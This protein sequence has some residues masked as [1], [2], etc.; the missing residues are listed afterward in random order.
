MT[1]TETRAKIPPIKAG[2]RDLGAGDAATLPAS[3]GGAAGAG[4]AGGG[5]GGGAEASA[6]GGGAAPATFGAQLGALPVSVCS[7]R[8]SRASAASR[9]GPKALVQWRILRKKARPGAGA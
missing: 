5:G 1:T 2:P 3:G 9:F 4:A 7:S 6:S 8:I